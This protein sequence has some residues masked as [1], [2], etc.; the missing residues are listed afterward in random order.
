MGKKCLTLRRR[1]L[2]L[3]ELERQDAGV[4]F[5]KFRVFRSKEIPYT[6]GI[7]F[8]LVHRNTLLTAVRELAAICHYGTLVDKMLR[9]CT[10]TGL[11]DHGHR[12]RLLRET[13]LT[14][15]KAID[16]CRA[17]RRVTRLSSQTAITCARAQ[18]KLAWRHANKHLITCIISTTHT[19]SDT[20]YCQNE[21]R[22][23][24]LKE[25]FKSPIYVGRL[26]G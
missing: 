14:L 20:S 21:L 15:Q 11:R 5:T 10:V 6:N 23:I 22:T 2:P 26:Y 19:N 13:K 7:L 9:N 1:N 25:W 24:F 12:G 3:T 8:T 17:N 18:K 16:F 4:I